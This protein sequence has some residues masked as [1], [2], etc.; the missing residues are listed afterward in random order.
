[1]SKTFI[2]VVGEEQKE[3][4][5]YTDVAMRS[6]K[7]FQA[8][9]TRDW[10][11]SRTNRVTLKEVSAIHFE[12]YLQWL[13]TNDSSHLDEFGMREAAKLYILGDFLDDSA[14]RITMLSLF[15][16]D[17]IGNNR[18]PSNAIVTPAWEQT[19]ENSPLRKII[20]EIWITSS[21]KTMA[22]RFAGIEKDVPKEFIVDCL[23]RVSETQARSTERMTNEDRKRAIESRR[24]EVLKELDV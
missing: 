22:T 21:I 19:P 20:V 10:I 1:M 2:A 17:A 12:N 6:S 23:H 18:Y 24:D 5:V 3:F 16:K 8:A 7:F 14:F 15:A 13:S 4:T 11:E 9:L